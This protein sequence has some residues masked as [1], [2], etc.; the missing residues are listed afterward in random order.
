M[1]VKQPLLIHICCGPCAAHPVQ[2]LR[3]EY[4]IT[5]FFFNPNI[6]PSTEFERRLKVVRDYLTEMNI[7]L[8]VPGQTHRLWLDRVKALVSEPEGGSRCAACFEYR[9]E[10]TAGFAR[11]NGFPVFTTTLTTGPN[12]PAKVIFPIAGEIAGKHCVKFLP[13]DFKKKDGYKHST[14]ISKEKNMY[15]QNYCGC[16]FSMR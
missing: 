4:A 5:G 3:A 15:R 10:A 11:E 13:V 2:T 7:P 14:R 16:E 12:K 1:K 8:I 9:L 6:Y